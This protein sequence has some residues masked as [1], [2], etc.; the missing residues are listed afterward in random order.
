MLSRIRGLW[1]RE[2]PPEELFVIEYPHVRV[3][4]CN[5]MAVGVCRIQERGVKDKATIRRM[6]PAEI[7]E[8]R[9]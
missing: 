6:T 2:Q 4:N 8:H 3:W 5:R 7:E 1:R 9:P